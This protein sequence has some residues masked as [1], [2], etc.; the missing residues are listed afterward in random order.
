[1]ERVVLSACVARADRDLAAGDAAVI[2]RGLAAGEA[3]DPAGPEVT[4]ALTTLYRRALLR[5]P[6]PRELEHLRGL[7]RDLSADGLPGATRD[8][9]VLSCFSV[10]TSVE[11]LFY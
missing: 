2:Y 5:D 4:G 11:A 1:V 10:L 6:K 9:A 8:W 7:Y 3:V